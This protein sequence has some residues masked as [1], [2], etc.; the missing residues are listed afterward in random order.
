[1]LK[2]GELS[3]RSGL[4]KRTIDYYTNLGLLEVSYIDGNR[5]R[6][7]GEENLNR[8]KLIEYYKAKHLRLEEIKDKLEIIHY[9]MDTD[10]RKKI[11]R[12]C[13][14]LEEA[15][16]EISELKTQMGDVS[17][18]KKVLEDLGHSKQRMFH[19]MVFLLEM[20]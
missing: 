3:K 20:L 8:I 11:E 18:I 4:T 9:E 7:Y 10:I 12:I 16:M 17:Q 5:Y 13:E 1:M 15:E 6:Q 2:I 19:P 14:K